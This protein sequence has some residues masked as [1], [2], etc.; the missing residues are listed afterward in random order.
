MRGLE[1]IVS[2]IN[3]KLSICQQSPWK[4]YN[5][6]VVFYLHWQT[7]CQAFHGTICSEDLCPAICRLMTCIKVGA[8]VSVQVKAVFSKN[9]HV[10]QP[11]IIK[12]RLFRPVQKPKVVRS[13]G[14]IHLYTLAQQEGQSHVPQWMAQSEYYLRSTRSSYSDRRRRISIRFVLDSSVFRFE[15]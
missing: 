2:N 11:R 3:S 10:G 1:S 4:K 14:H 9:V 8:A 6:T 13:T 12:V 15:F 5:R 7:S